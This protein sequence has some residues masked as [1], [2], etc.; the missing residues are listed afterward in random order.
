MLRDETTFE[1]TDMERKE[2]WKYYTSSFVRIEP[3]EGVPRDRIRKSVL[4]RNIPT[5]ETDSDAGT[6]SQNRK[7][8]AYSEELI[9]RICVNTYKMTYKENTED[10]FIYANSKKS[11][12]DGANVTD[13]R[14]QRF[15]EKF[16]MNSPWK[17]NLSQGQV[18]RINEDFEKWVKGDGTLPNA[19]GAA[20]ESDN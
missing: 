10:W 13:N 15:K 17:K 16:E 6:S 18:Q 9:I 19:A 1:L 14:N 4:T 2:R 3:T 11:E 5:A 12:G 20:V 7:P 8:I